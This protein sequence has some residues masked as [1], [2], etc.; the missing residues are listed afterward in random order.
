MKYILLVHH[1]EE[2]IEQL[3]ETELGQLRAESVQLANQIHSSG[4]YVDAA[5]LHP[6]STATCVRVREGKLLVTDGPF[7]ETREQLGGYFLITA[8]N[9]DE[10][11]AIGGRIPGAR[12]GTVEIRPVI[13]L[14]GLP[15][16]RIARAD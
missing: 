1:S 2:V 8:E 7:A 12:I 14:P 15:D 3:G 13:E 5:P 11:I 6:T 9:L 4:K 10:A 16:V